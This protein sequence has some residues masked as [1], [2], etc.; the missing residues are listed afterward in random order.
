MTTDTRR[1]GRQEQGRRQIQQDIGRVARAWQDG[2]QAMFA[3]YGDQMRRLMEMN[4]AFTQ[5]RWLDRD[6]MRETAQRFTQTTREVTTAQVAVFGEWLR[7]PLWFTGQ[8]SPAD[9]QAR[10]T[11]LF[12]AQRELVRTYLDAALGAQRVMAG[13]TERA[14][15]VARKAVDA[16]TETAQKVASDVRQAQ[17]ATIDATRQTANGVRQA[18][19]QAAENT[20]RVVNQVQETATRAATEA[21]EATTR[22]AER[23]TETTNRAVKEASE[24][25]KETTDRA[26]QAQR[27]VKGNINSRGEKIY[28]I[29]GQA[30]YERTD[31]DET[32]ATEEEAQAAGYRR[33]QSRGGG[34]IKGHVSRDGEKIFHL[35][36]QA[37]YDR[38]EADALFET[39]EAAIAA[40]F[41]AAQR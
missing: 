1:E 19:E 15:E 22:A 24:V 34:S 12:E 10:Y 14:A 36:G 5:P 35:P 7:A 17:E 30:T 9:L 41:R 8:A 21:A 38:I 29:P 6:E 39:E 32:F 26:A 16:Q 13:V 3:G 25:V 23:A 4:T 20:R 40:G 11:R 27:P 28:H 31:A 2:A 37:N 33:S 18:T